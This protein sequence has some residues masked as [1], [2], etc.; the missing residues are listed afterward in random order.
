LLMP[1]AVIRESALDANRRFMA[2]FLAQSG[3]LLCPHGK[4]TMS[5]ELM[6]QQIADG[7]WGITAATWPQAR[8]MH[9]AGIR[10]VLMANQLVGKA[11][12]RE[13]S[14]LLRADPGFAFLA[15]VDSP[16]LVAHMDGL[17]DLPLGARIDVLVEVGQTGART[18]ARTL[19]VALETA[20][21]V[22]TSRQLR[23]AGIETYE[24]IL[25]GTDAAD[26]RARIDALYAL[27]QDVARACADEALFGEDP[28]ILSGGGSEFFDRA[29]AELSAM[30]PGRAC[31]IVLRSG[32]YLTHDV[33]WLAAASEAMFARSPDVAANGL[34]PQPALDVWAAIH[35][36]PE[37]GL[38]FA[39]MGKRDVS[40]DMH[41]PVP[42][43]WFRPGLHDRPQP[44]DGV[45]VRE[46][47]DQHTHL[48]LGSEVDLRIG[49]LIGFG[50][51]H[52][53]TTFDK[54]T[55]IPVVDDNYRVIRHIHCCF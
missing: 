31:R 55:Q 1:C 21:A 37:P 43:L 40:F 9:A 11:E 13:L 41:L 8:L 2:A 4:T 50:I 32:C 46:L 27:T 17:L 7:A 54:W 16:E 25:A 44:L 30:L 49:D 48:V 28:V 20:R 47:N 12:L 5:P 35:S 34:R 6:R 14:A 39:N 15:L 33:R 38:A 3:A 45:T 51:S 19:C 42:Q 23:L 29:A 10:R 36:R 26:M 22:A 24:G 18:G 52:P 53:C